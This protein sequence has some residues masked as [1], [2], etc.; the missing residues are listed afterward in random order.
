MVNAQ[1]A[2]RRSL[3]WGLAGV[4]LLALSFPPVGLW[5]CALL[6]PWPLGVCAAGSSSGR[7]AFGRFCFLGAC[8][9]LSTSWWLAETHVFNLAVV[10]LV[11][12]PIVGL[13]G[14]LGWHVFRRGSLFPALPALWTAHEMFRLS[15]PET[16]YGWGFV[17]HALAASPVLVQVADLGGV[18]LVSFVGASAATAVWAHLAGRPGRGPALVV[19]LLAILYGFIRPASLPEE[20]PGPLLAS[21]QPNFA[22]ELKDDGA[23]APLRWQRCF[24]LVAELGRTTPDADLVIFPET[25][26]PWGVL[27]DGRPLLAR[28]RGEG[29]DR[30]AEAGYG[31]AE[32][33]EAQLARDQEGLVAGPLGMMMGQ[34]PN[35]RPH[36][37]LGAPAYGLLAPLSNGEQEPD[38]SLEPLMLN[39]AML[40]GPEGQPL[41]RYDK[42]ILIPGG[43]YIPFRGVFPEVV[44]SWLDRMVRDLA[45]FVPDVVPGPGP[46]LLEIP[47]PE[48][49]S[50]LP[51]GVTICFENAYGGYNRELV[52]LGARFLVNLSNEGWFGTSAEFDHMELHSVLRAV[53]TRRALFRS[54]NT[55]I[56]CLV[57]PDGRRP[58]GADRLAVGGEDRGIAGTFAARVPIQTAGTL[59][60]V[61]GD[62]VGWACLVGSLALFLRRRA[63]RV[64]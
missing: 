15:W 2:D 1:D 32:E 35:G 14:W 46:Q 19:V 54:T 11:E 38:P 62:A 40:Y 29:A 10:T 51:I 61:W 4:A 42:H 59:Y 25:M 26:W 12:A 3:A 39:S 23:A 43:E 47:D 28:H 6:A 64:A 27:L 5:V 21:I 50:S 56:S 34:F 60:V 20:Q 24:A 33:L 36:W 63:P 52:A 57:R 58:S 31:S 22:Q 16:G 9:L 30:S 45:G 13:F 55:G 18:L 53:E 37:L 48:G 8:L 49:D 41:G 17:G 44:R 7:A